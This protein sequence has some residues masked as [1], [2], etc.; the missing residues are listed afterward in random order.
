M[1][2]RLGPLPR[3]LVHG[4]ALH[5]TDQFAVG[6]ARGHVVNG[7]GHQGQR[8]VVEDLQALVGLAFEDEEPG[9]G[10][11]PDQDGRFDAVAS[12]ELDRR[13]GIQPGGF[14]VAAP[15][16]LVGADHRH[17]GVN[18]CLAHVDDQPLGAT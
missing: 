4:Q 15:Q 12:S 14:H 17:D 11:P 6:H 8:D 2:H 7:T 1:L 5:G 16:P 13:V 18:R 10:D 3:P 9:G